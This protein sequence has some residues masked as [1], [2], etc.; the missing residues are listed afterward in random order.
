MI[1]VPVIIGLEVKELDGFIET[2]DP[3]GL[4]LWINTQDEQDEIVILRRLEF[5][6]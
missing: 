2:M 1:R 3:D 5:W 4:F 6:K